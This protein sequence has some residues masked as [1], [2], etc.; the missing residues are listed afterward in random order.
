MRKSIILL[1]TLFL[2]GCSNGTVEPTTLNAEP[3]Y[4]SFFLNSEDPLFT[5]KNCPMEVCTISSLEAAK[6]WPVNTTLSEISIRIYSISKEEFQTIPP[7]GAL[8]AM[9]GFV[10]HS[11]F[12]NL[13][14]LSESSV[15]VENE[16]ITLPFEKEGYYYIELEGK[17]DFYNDNSRDYHYFVEINSTL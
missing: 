10:N 2:L 9:E 14:L 16:S 15:K 5:E 12:S 4:D 3:K 6:I 13:E 7:T 8:A 11:E 17:G 1:S